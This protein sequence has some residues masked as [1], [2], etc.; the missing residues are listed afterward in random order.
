LFHLVADEFTPDVV[1]NRLPKAAARR[2]LGHAGLGMEAR[3]R[4]ADAITTFGNVSDGIPSADELDR[5]RFD[6]RSEP[7]RSL[8]RRVR[9]PA[10]SS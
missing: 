3:A 2:L 4:L 10:P 9:S 1:W 8:Y 5:L 6:R 7:Y